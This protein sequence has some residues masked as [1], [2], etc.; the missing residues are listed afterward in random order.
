MD[1]KISIEEARDSHIKNKNGAIFQVFADKKRHG[2]VYL[3]SR[4]KYISIDMLKLKQGLV[5]GEWLNVNVGELKTWISE[6]SAYILN[7]T[8]KLLKRVILTQLLIELD[9]ELIEDYE[10]EK[11]FRNHLL[12]TNKEAERIASKN[13]DRLY[14]VDK[15]ILQNFMREIDELTAGISSF[16]LTDYL[17]LNRMVADYKINPEKYQE[18]SIEFTKID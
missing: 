3:R 6:D 13:Y 18:K 4:N 7:L 10:N 1:K 11:T 5:N 8:Q 15:T 14:N 17:H 2:K 9:D 16:E 12:K